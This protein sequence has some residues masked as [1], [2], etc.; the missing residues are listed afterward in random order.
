M[1]EPV[2]HG[3]YKLLGPDYSSICEISASIQ[4]PVLPGQLVFFLSLLLDYLG[5]CAFNQDEGVAGGDQF[6]VITIILLSCQSSNLRSKLLLIGF[7]PAFITQ[8]GPRRVHEGARSALRI[9]ALLHSCQW[10]RVF[11]KLGDASFYE[12]VPDS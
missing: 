4:E 8:P 10:T 6:S 9:A 7:A 3:L 12:S 1:F 5:V 11:T 2:K